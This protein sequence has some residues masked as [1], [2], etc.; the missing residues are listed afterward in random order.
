MAKRSFLDILAEE[1]PNHEYDLQATIPGKGPDK[2]GVQIGRGRGNSIA[3]IELSQALKRLPYETAAPAIQT[4]TP[5]EEQRTPAYTFTKSF[6]G[7]RSGSLPAG[8]TDDVD[9]ELRQAM[10]T[11]QVKLLSPQMEWR[12][13][14]DLEEGR[15]VME[16]LGEPLEPLD[17]DLP[18]AD[19]ERRR[20]RR[21]QQVAR[22]EAVRLFEETQAQL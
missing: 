22:E 11:R 15:V 5:L 21:A 10:T 14:A 4:E 7:V 12:R 16:D 9:V 6:S 1:T 13:M 8:L 17:P 2:L 20:R 18:D 3:S 19:E